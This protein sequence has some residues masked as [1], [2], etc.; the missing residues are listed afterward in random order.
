MMATVMPTREELRE[1]ALV[2]LREA[3]TLFGAELYDGC[4]YLCGYVVEFA[5]KACI[6][7]TLSIT[8]YPD[9]RPFLT[10][11]F[12]EL[13]LLA[14]LQEQITLASRVLLDN[15][16]AATDWKPEWRYQ[17]KGTHARA[18]AQERLDAIKADPDG[19]LTYLM[20]RW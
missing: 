6:C 14:G 9:S 17:R 7:A 8:A 20:G 15:W 18:D 16:S 1:L 3:E 12:E 4:V 13:K 5:L 19:V 10:H 11:D 2:R